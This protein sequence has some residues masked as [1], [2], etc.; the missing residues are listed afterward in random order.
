MGAAQRKSF[1]ANPL[2]GDPV[3]KDTHTIQG[4]SFC[5]RAATHTCCRIFG[6]NTDD[7]DVG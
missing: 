2:D 6:L 4:H 1:L 3:G 7:P 5:P